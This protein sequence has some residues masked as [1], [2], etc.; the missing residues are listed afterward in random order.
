MDPVEYLL[1]NHVYSGLNDTLP[2]GTFDALTALSVLTLVTFIGTWYFLMREETQEWLDTLG[3]RPADC[4]RS[5][6]LA[7]SSC[8]GVA[9]LWSKWLLMLEG[10]VKA[11]GEN[12]CYAY[13]EIPISRIGYFATTLFLGATFLSASY[14]HANMVHLRMFLGQDYERQFHQMLDEDF[15][16]VVYWFKDFFD[17]YVWK[18]GLALKEA[19]QAII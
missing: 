12:T 15:W 7:L 14:I 18:E 3:I 16:R 13:L 10:C 6:I 17:D 8:V 11:G 5:L 19:L 1:Q 4:L 2:M 9:V